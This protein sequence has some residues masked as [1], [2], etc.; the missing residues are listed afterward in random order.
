RTK[1]GRDCIVL[2]NYKFRE[3]RCDANGDLSWCCLGRN[4]NA[5]IR[6]DSAKLKILSVCNDIHTGEHPV[7]VSLSAV[8]CKEEV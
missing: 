1:S 3:S 7:T 4:C 2:D 5:S 6:T 8:A